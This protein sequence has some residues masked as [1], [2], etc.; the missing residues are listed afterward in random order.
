MRAR[1]AFA[2][3]AIVGVVATQAPAYTIMYAEEFYVLYH[4]QL[5]MSTDEIME[6]IV[7]L[8]QALAADFANPLY[9]LARVENKREW[10]QYRA[11]FKMHVN[12]KLVQMHLKLA[13]LYDKRVAYF[14]N[15]P[16]K[17]QNLESLK[18]AE[19]LYNKG[20]YYWQESLTWARKVRAF[21]ISLEEIQN[22]EDEAL[23]IRTGELDYRRIIAE[24]LSR[25]ERVRAAF[26][27]MGP[28]TY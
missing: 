21:G 19:G 2:A 6:N 27:A 12:L 22:W 28:G 15:A 8:E 7:W 3:L 14:F 24:Q 13:T 11:L 16:W 1:R 18:M 26:E 20:L 4:E 5:T 10:E 25:L 9:A 17:E 23:R